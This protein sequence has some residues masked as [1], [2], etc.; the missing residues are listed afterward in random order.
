MRKQ[1]T[2]TARHTAAMNGTVPR[3]TP[4]VVA[5]P[6]PP[7]K[8]RNTGKTCPSTA[9][10]PHASCAVGVT[11]RATHGARP[12]TA[13]NPLTRSRQNTSVPAPTP[14]TRVTLVAPT[15][16]LPTVRTSMRLRRFTSRYAVGIDPTR[17]EPVRA[18]IGPSGS[19][20]QREAAR[21]A[22]GSAMRNRIGTP[23]KSPCACSAFWR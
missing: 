22:G 19:M 8:P 7:R 12:H 3:R 20:A 15:F 5:T 18:R 21:R 11:G 17:Y 16:P 14:A 23:A 1:P 9:A 10:S 4:I 2:H 6:F 13:T